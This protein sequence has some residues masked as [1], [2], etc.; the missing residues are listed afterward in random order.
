M[1]RMRAPTEFGFATAAYIPPE[2][3]RPA[4]RTLVV[5]AL[6]AL[7]PVVGP[8]IS[9]VYVDRRNAPGSFS[10][11]EA[12]RTALIQIVAVLLL[13]VLLWVVFVAIFGFSIDATLRLGRAGR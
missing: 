7:I 13:A 4:W 2:Q 12:L 1:S 8:G 11:A 9:A 3:P 10:F 6:L 5:A